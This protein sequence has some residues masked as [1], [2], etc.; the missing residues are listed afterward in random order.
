MNNPNIHRILVPVDFSP[1]G[2]SAIEYGAYLANLFNAKLFL[3]HVL[4]DAPKYPH[5]WQD[6]RNSAITKGRL[7]ENAT[8]KLIE[9]TRNV[10]LKYTIGVEYLLTEGKPSHKITETVS[11]YDIDLIV[12][13]THGASGFEELFIG[14]NAHKVANLSPC[15]VITIREGFH[16]PGLKTIVLPIDDSL[17]SRQKVNNVIPIA[18]KCN[19]VIHLLGLTHTN[20]KSEIAKLHIKMKSMEEMAK[21]AGVTCVSKIING[22]NLAMETMGYAEEVNAEMLAI[23]TDHESTM[24]GSFMGAFAQQIV[25]HS[26]LPVLSIKPIKSYYEYAL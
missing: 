4:E 23:M 22:D 25:N 17:H 6:S 1:T 13:G 14:S 24:S 26:T 12:M 19:S 9:Y 7:R 10:K 8:N 21:K 20:S 15:P 18:K 3:L 5:E 16:I 2:E 11:E